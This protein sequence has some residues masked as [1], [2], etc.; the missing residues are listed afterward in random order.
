MVSRLRSGVP[1]GVMALLCIPAI[2]PYLGGHVPRTNDL[3]PHVYRAF[4][5][6]QLLRV[7]TLF[8]RWG[9]HLVHGYGY[10]VYNYFAYLSHY[11]I[12]LLHLLTNLDYLWA[13]RLAVI[14]VTMAS[15]CGAFLLSR[16][17][18]K[19]ETA[20]LFAAVGF[21]YSPYL[22]LTHHVRGGLPESLGL[23]ALPFALWTWR[24]AST[25]QRN[26]VV[27]GGVAYAAL[28]F[29]H[30]GFAV[31]VSPALL[32]FALWAGRDNWSRAFR[33]TAITAIA[34]LL[35][36]AFYWLPAIYELPFAKIEEGYAST[37][38][39]YYNNFSPLHDLFTYPPVPVDS[40]MLNPPVSNPV[41]V[42]ALGLAVLALAFGL[43]SDRQLSGE[44]LCLGT[45]A[46]CCLFLVLPQS[47]FIWDAIP[48]LQ[49]TLWPWRFVGPASLFIALVAS[50][51][52]CH[53]SQASSSGDQSFV[54]KLKIITG[55]VMLLI[56]MA[57]GIPWLYPPREK[58]S[59]P[60]SVANLAAF[61]MPPWLI[62]TSSTAE[63][64]PIWV[65]DLPDSAQQQAKLFSNPDPDRLDRARLRDGVL[66]EHTVNELLRDEYLV[67]SPVD[68]T[69]TFQHFFFPGWVA[70]VDGASVTIK[71]TNP[72]GLISI[73]VPA[74]S[75]TVALNFGSTLVRTGAG[76]LSFTTLLCVVF[77]LTVG[78][79]G[80]TR[81][82]ITPQQWSSNIAPGPVDF[83]K[84]LRTYFIFSLLIIPLFLVSAY[85]D[86]P[87]R[88][89]GLAQGNQPLNMQH[90]SGADFGGELWLHG[91]SLSDTS[92]AADDQVQ[93]DLYWQAQKPL[94]LVYGF[95]VR[96]IDA[97]GQ[98][99]NTLEIVRPVGWRFIPGTDFW[100]PDKYILDNYSVSPVSG[101]PPGEYYLEVVA[102]RRDTV[103]PLKATIIGKLDVSMADRSS[104][105]LSDPLAVMED[106]H[107][108]LVDLII[109][110]REAAPGD[111]MGVHAVWQSLGQ[112]RSTDVQLVLVARNGDR[113]ESFEFTL[114][115]DYPPNRWNPGDFVRDQHIFRLPSRL[116]TGEFEWRIALSD[117]DPVGFVEYDSGV[118]LKVVAPDRS[119]ELPADLEM[120]QMSMSDEVILEGYAQS[121]A[122]VQRSN[123]LDITLVWRALNDLTVP[124]RIF[125]HL[126]NSDGELIAQ[127]DG[128]PA[129]W[130]RPTTSWLPGEFVSDPHTLNIPDEIPDGTYR[131]YTGLYHPDTGGRL[132]S[133]Y[134][135][136]G[137]LFVSMIELDRH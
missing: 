65:V 27:W 96:L 18:F 126:V 137:S 91:Y 13:Y 105:S 52:G 7:G 16:D 123:T 58:M 85:I 30:N 127:S 115:G 32:A 43:S 109:D 78:K 84:S 50:H 35:L 45:L 36:S 107:L 41:S 62:G 118:E 42:S 113:V 116:Q 49:R 128:E 100:P 12:T 129:N 14:V 94:G 122:S 22:L 11:L 26:F 23:A 20:G 71:V 64:L 38:I 61:E 56:V 68:A 104:Y 21:I 15:A 108:A 79:R 114:G 76:L 74:G 57:N 2:Y 37:G 44:I 80:N 131:L 86:N 136:G 125:V 93:L 40:D 66:A 9:P 4:E 72:H 88:K 117:P 83:A 10:P 39:V 92:I 101:T 46:V 19:S 17:L 99:W 28:I 6:E 121:E 89:H 63:Y 111:L 5:L 29:S 55:P 31:Q 119:F 24:R 130:T 73:E 75:H 98:M 70:T 87:I 77:E 54:N 25:G 67:E 33:Y 82:Q 3:A 51:L 135:L 124:Y 90:T 97:R 110:R 103:Q 133:D 81:L 120:L 69:L 53:I 47:Q 8:P 95:N 132:A 34:G 59:P 106:S 112:V 102:F 48:I 1:F 134:D 60:E